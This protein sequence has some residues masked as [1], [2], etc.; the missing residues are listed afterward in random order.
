MLKYQ[1]EVTAA[2]PLRKAYLDS[3]G[4]LI[5]ERQTQFM[6][7]REERCADIVRNRDAA[8]QQ[9]IE[10]LGWPLTQA[11]SPVKSVKEEQLASDDGI[12]IVRM[13]FE[14]FDDFYYY[15]VLFRHGEEQLPLVISQHGAEGSPERC[16]GLL[17]GGS[18]NY[19]D[20]TQR[21]VSQHVNVFAPQMLL[22]NQEQYGIDYNRQDI[23]ARLRRLGG[24]ITALELYCLQCCMDYLE[25][26]TYIQKGKMGMC[27][28]SYGGFYTL[29]TAAID[30]RIKSAISCSFFNERAKHLKNDWAWKD[31]AISFGDSET[32]LLCYPR[33]LYLE[34]GMS[35]D[36]VKF[37]FVE[38]EYARLQ[39]EIR[40]CGLD[41][42]WVEFLPFQGTHEFSW[43]DRPIEEMVC[44]LK[45]SEG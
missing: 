35:D 12:Q 5:D 30:E 7:K 18:S 40:V 24:S 11:R 4:R 22:W 31:A 13:T 39:K 9:F 10:M 37:E 17:T 42:A 27:G 29:F 25:Q 28:L 34:V 20:M 43:D 33:K 19:N 14:I 16:S 1:E 45:E 2:T 38:R 26:Q 32:V 36:L 3:I 41:D 23:D 21:I 15:G 8:K 44:L 6:C